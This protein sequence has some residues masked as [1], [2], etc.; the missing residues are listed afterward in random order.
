LRL[1]QR[2]WRLLRAV[3][4]TLFPTKVE[5]EPPAPLSMDTLMWARTSA[6]V[7]GAEGQGTAVEEHE[8]PYSGGAFQPELPLALEPIAEAV[9]KE[10]AEP[11]PVPRSQVWQL[12]AVDMLDA[13]AT[14]AGEKPDNSA[15]A[16]LIVDTRG[17]FG[18]D[19]EVVQINEGPTVTQ[20]GI[21]PGWSRPAQYR[22]ATFSAAPRSQQPSR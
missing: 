5:A 9:E 17:S 1:P 16:R 19:A 18:V 6:P 10:S 15:R 13:A 12:P 22:S 3:V 8:A 11:P 2:T 7:D 20:F 4:D 14:S 21:E